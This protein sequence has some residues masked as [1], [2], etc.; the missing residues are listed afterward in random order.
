MGNKRDFSAEKQSLK[1]KLMA[2][3]LLETSKDYK[4][5]DSDLVT[6]CVDFLMELEEKEKLSEKEIEQRVNEIPFKGKVTAI[7]SYAKKRIRAKRLAVIAA[8][9]AVLIALFGLLAVADGDKSL[10]ILNDFKTAINEMLRGETVEYEN[11]T[12][13]KSNES[14]SYSS[15]EDFAEAENYDMLYPV[16]LPENEK[17]VSVWY[18]YEEPIERYIFYLSNPK[19]SVGIEKHKSITDEMM[20]GSY[21]VEIASF[22]VYCHKL[23]STI[24]AIFEHNGCL[25][26][27][28]TDT[29]DNLFKIIE[30]LEE[31]N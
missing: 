10:K 12:V 20:A 21:E 23:E 29:E 15:L 28:K 24:Q 27:V 4:K 2:I 1:D 5:M 16:W 30:N 26:I 18:I 11:I 17:I 7:G 14:V 13:I 6:E 8:V 3:I 9:L 22:T 31:I 25:Y 19:H